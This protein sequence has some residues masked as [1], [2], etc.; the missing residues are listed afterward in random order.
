[1]RFSACFVTCPLFAGHIPASVSVISR[2]TINEKKSSAQSDLWGNRPASSVGNQLVV[3]NAIKETDADG[4][5]KSRGGLG[6]C[7]KPV[8]RYNKTA[9]IIEFLEV[10]KV[11]GVGKFTLYNLTMSPEVR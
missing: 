3:N 11:L 10:N 2:K 7:V 9:E 1:M 5:V 6:V 8:F 4:K